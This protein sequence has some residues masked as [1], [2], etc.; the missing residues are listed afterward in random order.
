MRKEMK[1]A[2]TDYTVCMVRDDWNAAEKDVVT[3]LH[4]RSYSLIHLADE[5]SCEP[6]EVYGVWDEYIPDGVVLAWYDLMST[7]KAFLLPENA[8]V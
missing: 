5:L 7:N 4:V 6:K 3:I 1:R 8:N 2:K